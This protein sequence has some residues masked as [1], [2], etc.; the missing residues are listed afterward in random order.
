[1]PVRFERGELNVLLNHGAEPPTPNQRTVLAGKDRPATEDELRAFAERM[2]TLYG[3]E[4]KS[5]APAS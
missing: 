4:Q 1:M 3:D 2:W 5:E